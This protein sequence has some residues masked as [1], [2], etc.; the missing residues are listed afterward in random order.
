[1]D[2]LTRTACLLMIL[3]FILVPA[4]IIVLMIAA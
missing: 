3:M 1:M 2:V 4:R